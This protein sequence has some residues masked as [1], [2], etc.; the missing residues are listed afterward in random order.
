[1]SIQQQGKDIHE[2]LQ[3]FKKANSELWASFLLQT[4]VHKAVE[5]KGKASSSNSKTNTQRKS[6][7]LMGG[8]TKNKS[9]IKKAQD[10]V[11][12]KCEIIEEE[13]LDSMTLQNDLDLYKISCQET[14]Y[15]IQQLFDVVEE[16]KKKKKG[17]KE[18]KQTT[19]EVQDNAEEYV[20]KL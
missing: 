18:K 13:E 9:I 12:R 4:L 17:K 7:R 8:A 16:M 15:A 20:G 19:R 1:L 3:L 10:L 6:H 2:L 11:A 5:A 14:M